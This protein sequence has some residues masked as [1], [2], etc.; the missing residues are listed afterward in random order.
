MGLDLLWAAEQRGVRSTSHV[1]YTLTSVLCG[2]PSKL[3]F[4]TPNKNRANL[5]PPHGI[6]LRVPL[7]SFLSEPRQRLW[8]LHL[9]LLLP[10]SCLCKD[11]PPPSRPLGHRLRSAGL[12]DH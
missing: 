10:A 6:D 5:G 4:S 8:T 7:A 1:S 3:L 12:P 11:F 2:G 9:S